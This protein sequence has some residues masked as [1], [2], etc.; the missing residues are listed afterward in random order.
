MA[1]RLRDEDLVLNIIVNGDRGRKE[2]GQL[3]RSIRDTRQELDYLQAEEKKLR[4]EGK[5]NTAQ[6]KEVTEA[7]KQKNVAIDT[8]TARMK[9]LR[10]GIDLSNLSL[11]ELRREMTRVRKLRDAAGPMTASWR[12]HDAQLAKVTARYQELRAQS[13]LTGSTIRRM[14][15]S[16]TRAFGSIAAGLATFYAVAFGIRRATD[17]FVSIDD[18]V[19]DVQKT[20]GLAREEVLALNEVL[21]DTDVIDTR[22]LQEGLLGLARIA[23]KLG[24]EGRDNILG[25]VKASDQIAVAL[26]EDLGGDIEQSIN[27]VGKLVGIFNVSDQFGIEEGILR[28]GSTINELGAN[29]EANEGF[30]VDFTKRL[31]GMA[32]SAKIAISDIMGIGAAAD[33]AG[34]SVEVSGTAINQ[35]LSRMFEDTADFAKIAG[36]E[37]KQFS[38]LLEED[39]NEAFIKVLQGI[40]GNDESMAQLV[41][42]MQ[43]LGFDGV[44][45]KG[46]MTALAN[47]IEGLREQQLLANQAF[48]E[49]TSITDEFN[50]KN[51]NVA[52]QLEKSKKE[53]NNLWVELGERLYPVLLAGNDLLQVFLQ[54]LIT[55]IDFV[56]ENRK[57]I[58]ALTVAIASYTLL[59]TRA[60]IATRTA[61]VAMRLFNAVTK[62]NPLLLLISALAAGVTYLALYARGLTSAQKA[63]QKLNGITQKATENVIDERVRMEQ[64]LKIARDN[65]KS[66]SEREKAVKALNQLSPEYLGNLTLEKI[67]TEEA[68]KATESYID[69]LIRQAKIKA[70]TDEIAALERK[71][72]RKEEGEEL[73]FLQA[74]Y[75]SLLQTI[76]AYG[77]AG[78]AAY[79]M[80][81]QNSQ[82]YQSNIQS[83]IDLLEKE[84]SLLDPTANDIVG[85]PNSNSTNQTSG[86][87]LD[88]FDPGISDSI[89]EFR[90]EV[91]EAQM[92]AVELEKKSYQDRLKQAGLYGRKLRELQ[93]EERLVAEAL[94]AEHYHN[95]NQIDA[96]AIA[97]ELQRRQQAFDSQINA[98][99]IA[100][101]QE[102]Q[103]Y[104]TLEQAK[105]K[106]AETYSDEELSK[107]RTLKEAREHLSKQFHDRE[108]VLAEHQAQELL[109]IL[110]DVLANQ[111]WQGVTADDVLSSEEQE[112]LEARIAELKLQLSE[113]GLKSS[114]DNSNDTKDANAPD[115]LNLGKTDILGFTQDDWNAFIYNIQTGRDQIQT[116]QMAAMALTQTW[117][118]FNAIA[119]Q[120]EQRRLQS[121]EQRL[122]Q[123]RDKLDNK[124][125]RDLQATEGNADAQRRVR[126][127]Y[128]RDIERLDK[129]LDRERAI[130]AR[131]QAVRERNVALA[132]AVINTAAG[133]ARA[134][135]DYP[136]PASAIIG[137][138]VGVLGAVQIGSIAAQ[139]LPQIPGAESGGFIDVV[140]SQDRKMFRAKYEPNK[141]GYVD[142]PTVLT[143]ESGRE[144]VASNEAYNNPTIR[145]VLDI[146]DTAQRNGSISTVNLSRILQDRAP[147]SRVRGAQQGGMIDE[148]ETTSSQSAVASNPNQDLVALIR[149]TNEI[150]LKLSRQIEDGIEAS[151]SLLGKKGF[152][153]ADDEYQ[154]VLNDI[155][156]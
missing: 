83:E 152:Y 72:A 135:K 32:R 117:S 107:I 126:E 39:A 136:Y 1:K 26:T 4:A 153:E 58:I 70:I 118:M 93:G 23:G 63:Q 10:K 150:N 42:R 43:S 125:D 2:L 12:N 75:I 77:K 142:R 116:L 38:K 59:M 56:S 18:K 51:T 80:R 64:L 95:L 68:T 40:K 104:Q 143:G 90:Q 146:I 35:V 130:I 6:Y 46:V 139:P 110:Q 134:L 127:R 154:D 69:S 27:T 119:A 44:R 149:Q 132:S 129:R 122:N 155:N 19:A 48:S 92:S 79:S 123:E 99:Q 147:L 49:G 31:A 17:E 76:G 81:N 36:I 113:L 45:V 57:A 133:V 115:R 20:T 144:L 66:I 96:D 111:E 103:S 50:I 15:S 137:A 62:T 54:T 156:A 140:R 30:I 8:A 41:G 102:L 65:T 88:P 5:K 89:K 28:V 85:S 29:S 9:Q 91:L 3:E 112:I 109:A 21:K 37:V 98:L 106:L 128:N 13:Q 114:E 53:V 61:T 22:T 60:T 74:G 100:N 148:R 94:L 82:E 55:I 16:I 151:V 73:N 33:V 121:F 67:S 101:N 11:S 97:A 87:S 141:R 14:S 84:L 7:I 78:Q 71:K 86:P 52:A 24:I 25:F 105:A 138:L 124:L 34:Q 108:A 131:K 145:P 47:N 120:S